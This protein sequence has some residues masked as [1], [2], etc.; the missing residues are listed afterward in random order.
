MR[1]TTAL[2]LMTGLLIACQGPLPAENPPT[3]PEQR[4]TLA[5]VIQ[6]LDGPPQPAGTSEPPVVYRDVSLATPESVLY[7][8]EADVYLVS[9][10]NG[11]PDEADNNGFISVLL[12]DGT[13]K[14]LKWIEGGQN[15]TRLSAP[16]GMVLRDRKLWV[17]DIDHLRR[18]DVATGK[19][20]A[21]IAVPGATFLNDITIDPAG[22]LYFS[23][24]GVKTGAN[25]FEPTG[26]DAIY[27][28]EN[29]KPVVV[30]KDRKLKW[31]N[32]VAFD[33]NQL[34]TVTLGGN[35]LL[36]LAADGQVQ[37]QTELPSGG[38]DGLVVL[39]PDDL[40]VS[41]WKGSVV[42]RG[43]FA[44]G[45]KPVAQNQVSPADIGFDTQRKRILIPNFN[46]HTVQAIALPGAEQEDA[47]HSRQPSTS[48]ATTTTSAPASASP[49]APGAA[50][51]KSP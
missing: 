1:Q 3:E 38:L 48:A 24:S 27:R 42:Y 17:T 19:P 5:P 25:G 50:S 7:D 34:L 35:Q 22:T 44:S 41:S 20:E 32:G 9:N 18:F 28:L 45:F 29:D 2:S 8:A 10:I 11:K 46:E 37:K 13:V 49:S 36:A 40:L 21:A 4:A 6:D 43:G 16:K 23:D 14:D 12:P 51:A 31:P 30:T 33:G 39:G 26:V 15:G 47:A